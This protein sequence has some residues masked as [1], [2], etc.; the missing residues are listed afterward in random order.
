MVS[1][2]ASEQRNRLA[3]TGQQLV[4]ADFNY[5]ATDLVREMIVKSGQGVFH[6]MTIMLMDFFFSG[7]VKGT[8]AKRF[9]LIGSSAS[10][11]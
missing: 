1:Q 2:Y 5:V 9:V 10:E 6:W 11:S 4:A 7:T 8:S 3:A